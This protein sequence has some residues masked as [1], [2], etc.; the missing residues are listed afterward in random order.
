VKTQ[1]ER[2]DRLFMSVAPIERWRAAVCRTC[3]V[4]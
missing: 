4:C 2:E 3:S 1:W